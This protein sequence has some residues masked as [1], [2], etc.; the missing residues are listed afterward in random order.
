MVADIT[1]HLIGI[2]I[3]LASAGA[4]SGDNHIDIRDNV[5][6][7]TGQATIVTITGVIHADHANMT[8]THPDGKI[9]DVSR[10]RVG[11]DAS[12]LTSVLL[13]DSW[14]KGVY[15]VTITPYDTKK[16]VQKRA[17]AHK[18]MTTYFLLSDGRDGTVDINI[19]KNAARQCEIPDGDKDGNGASS[20]CIQPAHTTIPAGFAVRFINNDYKTHN[21]AF[22]TTSR[23]SEQIGT[24]RITPGEEYVM[25][26]DTTT[27]RN[28]TYECTIHPWLTGQLNVVDIESIRYVDPI[29]FVPP[30][31][32][33]TGVRDPT[34]PDASGVGNLLYSMD[35]CDDCITGSM[36]G[37]LG[38][39]KI[40]VG[41]HTYMLTLV[42]HHKDDQQP[43]IFI[44]ETCKFGSEVMVNPDG[45]QQSDKS[46]HPYVL[47][48]CGGTVLNEALIASGHTG[49]DTM[50]CTATEFAGE[51]WVESACQEPD[52]VDALQGG[53]ALS[54]PLRNTTATVIREGEAAAE[55][56]ASILQNATDIVEGVVE[57]SDDDTRMFFV[58]GSILVFVV[59]VVLLIRRRHSPD[60]SARSKDDSENFIYLE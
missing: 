2:A 25:T 38:S 44:R 4:I 29:E 35:G 5:L 51:P 9:G 43:R 40:R 7:H 16:P 41:E 13:L 28:N 19:M 12:F 34:N 31:T 23:E 20:L 8:L 21:F 47:L 57:Y 59:C 10:H 11:D 49:A 18:D 54:Q 33:I 52:L 53:S 60:H 37:V 17:T 50:Q 55:Q 3:S 6:Q 45:G 30:P 32:I 36:T 1:L 27:P 14:T 56:A 26:L 58:F 39:N 24:G 22:P 46:G 48:T 15:A 42:A